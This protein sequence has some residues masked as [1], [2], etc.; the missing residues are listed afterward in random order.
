MTREIKLNKL[1]HVSRS[2]P[3]WLAIILLSD[4]RCTSQHSAMVAIQ[5]ADYLAACQFGL[6]TEFQ[7]YSQ[8]EIFSCHYNGIRTLRRI[9]RIRQRKRATSVPLFCLW[10]RYNRKR[11]KNEYDCR[12][13]SNDLERFNFLS[14]LIGR[15]FGS[16]PFTPSVC[17]PSLALGRASLVSATFF[18]IL[19]EDSSY[20]EDIKSI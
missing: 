18:S 20:D 7:N 14:V 6:V 11:W 9:V 13:L 3:L 5:I 19:N 12:M 17:A 15:K 10:K 4:A 16:A 1:I 2:E 8:N